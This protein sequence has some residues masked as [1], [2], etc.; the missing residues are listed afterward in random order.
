MILFIYNFVYVYVVLV[1]IIRFQYFFLSVLCIAYKTK[2]LSSPVLLNFT[3]LCW[4][5][6]QFREVC[7]AS[8]RSVAYRRRS[9]ELLRNVGR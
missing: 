9:G 7:T 3:L 1:L 8:P 5:H 2:L 6:C 4:Q